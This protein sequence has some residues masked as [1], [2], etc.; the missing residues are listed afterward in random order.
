ML[1]YGFQGFIGQTNAFLWGKR[2]YPDGEN[3]GITGMVLY[4]VTRAEN[5]PELAA[6]E[7]WEPGI[8]GVTVNLYASGGV[9]PV[10]GVATK[11][12]LLNTTTTDS[13]DASIPTGCKFGDSDENSPFMFSPDGTTMLRARLLGRPAH[14]QPGPAGGL[15]RR[16]CVRRR[17]RPSHRRGL[18][19]CG[20]GG[21]GVPGRD[22]EPH[23]GRRLHRRGHPSP[24]LRDP[25]A[26]GQERRLRRRVQP[27]PRAA[28]GTVRRRRCTPFRRS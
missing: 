26:R 6:A 24:G 15:R 1:T 20:I 27:G 17:V 28:A 22:G 14:V 18:L 11:G 4:A 8:P 2:H 23:A 3:G 7:V 10:T 12:A 9:D 5:D 16:V 19:A 13:W 25:Q 21:R